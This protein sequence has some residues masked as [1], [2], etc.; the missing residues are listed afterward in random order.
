[1]NDAMPR[2]NL[3]ARGY[4]CGLGCKNCPYDPP[5]TKDVKKIKNNEKKA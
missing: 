2:K 5:H 4:C 3:L 1:M